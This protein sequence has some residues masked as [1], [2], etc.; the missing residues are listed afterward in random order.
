HFGK[1]VIQCDD[2]APAER[3]RGSN[4]PTFCSL[5]ASDKQGT[6]LESRAPILWCANMNDEARWSER[7]FSEQSH[8][9]STA[10]IAHVRRRNNIAA[11]LVYTQASCSPH[12]TPAE[13]PVC[14][15]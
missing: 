3:Y 4:E 14:S 2:F 11:H 13:S 6:P 5:D 12:P 15:R 10:W 9:D 8:Y 1:G 7:V